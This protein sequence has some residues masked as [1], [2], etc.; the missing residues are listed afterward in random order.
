MVAVL[1]RGN[2]SRANVLYELGVAIGAGKQLIPVV[3]K[4][5][6]ITKLPF[7]IRSRR[8]LTMGSPDEAA[9]QIVEALQPAL[10]EF[11]EQALVAEK[12]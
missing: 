6:D 2:E 5:A 9:R 10:G 11:D 12:A 8:F 3:A 4:D 1:S 7:A